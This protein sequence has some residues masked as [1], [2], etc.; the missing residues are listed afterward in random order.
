MPGL[1]LP[2]TMF[3]V[4][5]AMEALGETPRAVPGA[6]M[7]VA[8]GK[9]PDADVTHFQMFAATMTGT[10]VRQ[11]LKVLYLLDSTN[12]EL[13]PAPVTRQVRRNAE[14]QGARI[15]WTVRLRQTT[16][17]EQGDQPAGTREYSHRFEVRGNFAHYAAGTWLYE[18]SAP[19]EIKPC[20][21][22]GTCRRV[23]RPAHIK[24]PRDRPLAIKIRRIEFDDD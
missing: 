8:R 9:I 2:I 5:A 15:A 7:G 16:R 3:S 13:A 18:H 20:P 23:W 21:R 10:A 24:G 6:L 12:V 11:T 17:A 1:G 22:C 4:S 14:R 19:E